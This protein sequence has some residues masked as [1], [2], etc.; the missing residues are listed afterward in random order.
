MPSLSAS[1]PTP[2]ICDLHPAMTFH[3]V[4][5]STFPFGSYPTTSQSE[6]TLPV[7]LLLV[8]QHCN[9]KSLPEIHSSPRSGIRSRRPTGGFWSL[10]GPGGVIRFA[11]GDAG[12]ERDCEGKNGEKEMEQRG[13]GRRRSRHLFGRHSGLLLSQHQSS[14]TFERYSIHDFPY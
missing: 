6:S 2:L 14:F 13:S 1:S 9:V 5:I 7:L 12:M 8:D 11:R 4:V 10:L 3:P